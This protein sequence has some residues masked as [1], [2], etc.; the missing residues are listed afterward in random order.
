MHARVDEK[1]FEIVGPTFSNTIGEFRKLFS[2]FESR[3]SLE[4]YLDFFVYKSSLVITEAVYCDISEI[5]CSGRKLAVSK[6]DSRGWIARAA[7]EARE[8]CLRPSPL[9]LS[10]ADLKKAC[11]QATE[12]KKTTT[13]NFA[14]SCMQIGLDCTLLRK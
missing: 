11:L 5:F 8:D 9:A 10:A 6:L 1:Y 7:S 13:T 2:S 3:S 14:T 12:K 4:S